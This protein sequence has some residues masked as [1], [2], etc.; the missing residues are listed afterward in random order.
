MSN[1]V[2]VGIYDAVGGPK[3]PIMRADGYQAGPTDKGEYVIAYCA[4]HS[5]PRMY[6]TWSNIRWGT[7]LRERKGIL[8]VYINGKWQALKNFTSATKT[9]IQ[10]YHQQLYGSWKV[11]KTWVF[12]DFGHITCYFFQDINKNR[13]LDGK[14]RIHAEF[15]HTTPG[16]EAQSAQGKPVILT[17][18]HGCIH[19]EPSDIDNMIKNGYLNKG[20]TLIIHSYPDTAPIW[21]WG[22]GTPPFEVHFF[23]GAKKIVIKGKGEPFDFKKIY[24]DI[25]DSL[26]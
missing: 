21:P 14:E 18:S 15:V 20:N 23:P 25:L 26:F 19:V 11:P 8:E 10:D 2:I 24:H 22:I 5:S 1:K 3:T 17:E 12:N 7:P 9:D 16:N 4:K 13:R 6:R